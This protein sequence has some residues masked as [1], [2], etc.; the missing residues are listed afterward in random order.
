MVEIGAAVVF[1]SRAGAFGIERR[2]VVGVPRVA[3]IERAAPREGLGSAAGAGR[4]H[5]VEHVD[6]ARDRADDVGWLADAHEIAWTIGGERRHR[7]GEDPEHFLLA[8]AAGGPPHPITPEAEVPPGAGP[9]P[10]PPPAD[11]ALDGAQNSAAPP[12]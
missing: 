7:L 11:P 4:Q 1:A 2:H 8:L 6:A 10:G 12:R 3:Q 9:K 5:A